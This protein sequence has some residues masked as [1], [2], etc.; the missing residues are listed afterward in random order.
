MHVAR[1]QVMLQVC[2]LKSH[3]MYVNMNGDT[4][5]KN[6]SHSSYVNLL[7]YGTKIEFNYNFEPSVF[8]SFFFFVSQQSQ[9]QII[10]VCG[11][12]SG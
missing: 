7:L 12:R 5:M 8:F 4:Q 11:P 9:N 1:I 3:C 6:A 10:A 2:T